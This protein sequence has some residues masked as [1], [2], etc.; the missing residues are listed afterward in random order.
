MLTR[1]IIPCLDVADGRV[2]KGVRFR[3][4]RDAGDP[5]EL[6]RAYAERGADELVFLDIAATRAGE[7]T[8]ARL[9]E[10][11]ARAVAIP[12]T[13]G[14][15]IRSVEDMRRVLDA[16][17]DK[18]GI[19]TAAV[20]RPELIGEAA[21]RLGSQAVVVAIDAARRRCGV[22]AQEGREIPG[23]ADPSWEVRV[24]AGTESAEIDVVEWA[25]RAAE[26]GAGEILLTSF[27]RD[28]TKEGYD[29]EL[30]EAVS[31]AV[32]IPV[33]ASGGAGEVEHFAEAFEAGAAAALAAS[34]FHYEELS[35]A[36]VKR[37]L[38][39]RGIP[40][41]PA[42]APPDDEFDLDGVEFDPDGV[43]FDPDTGLVAAIVQSAADRS[44][45]MLGWMNREALDATLD[46]GRVTFYSR[47][48]EEL[49][50]KGATSGNWL[51]LRS[52]RAD[53]DRDALLVTAHPHGPTCHTGRA[54]C[55][56]DSE[57]D[58]P[59]GNTAAEF[60]QTLVRLEGRIA[61]RAIERPTGSY[62]ASLLDAGR[63]RI[64]QKVG[65]EAVETIV[66]ALQGE[67]VRLERLAEESADLLY[68]L[69]V[70]WRAAG[71][72]SESV[73]AEL[74]RR[75]GAGAGKAA[76]AEELAGD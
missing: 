10:Q 2:V 4:L 31:S 18:V 24:T 48:R 36:A 43:E 17:A 54:S 58:G 53:C 13:V 72:D 38:A 5:V 23:V 50:E 71:L 69:L 65:E 73:A 16:G 9:A 30:V 42:P 7:A 59:A 63:E 60:G 26:L 29:L 11:V 57:G 14:G 32:R 39:S 22:D 15:G 25:R 33:I 44:V 37:H 64:A 76:R 3:G 1:R 56:D 49:W 27:D 6:A 70:L 40:V 21:E 68:H 35:I 12:F 75:E 46:S 20:R 47:S 41:R 66:A 8:A 51:E 28:G 19:N 62:T 61:E 45:L 52:I 67:D 34:L 55:F 74:R